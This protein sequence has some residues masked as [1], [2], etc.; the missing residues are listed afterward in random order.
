MATNP[1][2]LPVAG[3]GNGLLRVVSNRDLEQQ[4]QEDLDRDEEQGREK[5][6]HSQLAGFVRKQFTAADNHRQSEE[7]ERTHLKALRQLRGEY[8]PDKIA[9]IRQFRGSEV[10]S[11]LTAVKCRGASAL[12]RDI[13]LSRGRPWELAPTPDPVI[14]DTVTQNI[15]QLVMVEAQTAQMHGMPITPDVIEQRVE[16]LQE[17]ARVAA[18]RKA[19]SE[20]AKDTIKLDDILTE[21]GFYTA[22]SEFV[23]DLPVFQFAVIKGPV[24]RKATVSQWQPDGS[25]KVTEKPQMYWYRVNPLD[26]WFAPG[27]CDARSGPIIERLRLTSNE[28]YDLI[29]LP[30]YD[31]DAIRDILGRAS[32]GGLHMWKTTFESERAAL[33][34]R[35]SPFQDDGPFIDA[36]EFHGYVRG[37]ML[38]DWG[39]EDEEISDPDREYYA[40]VWLIDNKV[41]KAQLNPHPRKEPI[42]YVTSF[43]KVPGS[44]YGHGLPEILHDVQEVSNATLRALVNNLSIASGPQVVINLDSMANGADAESLYPW[45]RWYVQRDPLANPNQKPVDF[46]QP[47]SNAQELLV[48]YEKFTQI[49]DEVSAI[50][51]YL[52][53]SERVGGAA[54]TA[55]GLSMLMDNSS[56]VMQSVAAN[57]DHDVLQPLLQNLYD[58]VM[59]VDQGQTLRGDEHIVVRGVTM[60]IRQEQDRVRQLEFLQMTGNPIDMAVVGPKGR[61]TLLR[62]L[63]NNLGLD[64]EQIVPS[65]EEIDAM[66]QAQQAA[67]EQQQGAPPEEPPE[68]GASQQPAPSGA[69]N[70][71][72]GPPHLNLTGNNPRQ[73]GV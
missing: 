58:M 39:L 17:A 61:A 33:E 29:G 8:E 62:N 5:L 14:P 31:E 6:F 22:L 2:A 28:L 24:V 43:E 30:G 69:D 20:A 64:F 72:G 73:S 48:V 40:T 26:I 49:A 68:K 15:E 19:K 13:Y 66:L 23:R 32:G 55:S 11:R 7:I 37:Q 1:T 25:L 44:L 67:A 18:R 51:R 57:I 27:A 36:L 35:E 12:L 59:L 9:A 3:S 42:Y 52:T 34:R 47:Q 50:P 65:D 46:Y 10:Y 56:K 70:V 4:E 60:S 41:I 38:L 53:G 16:Q 54:S 63:A 71:A 45:K 21:G